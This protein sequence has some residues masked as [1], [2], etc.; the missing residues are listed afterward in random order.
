MRVAQLVFV[1][2]VCLYFFAMW[3]ND[4]IQKHLSSILLICTH[5]V[6]MIQTQTRCSLHFRRIWEIPLKQTYKI[7]TVI[8]SS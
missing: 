3:N 7:I 6:L 2:P 4:L 1:L 5:F 8:Y